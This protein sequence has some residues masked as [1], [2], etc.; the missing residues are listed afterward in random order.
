MRE[1]TTEK[2]ALDYLASHIAAEA[3][4]EGAPLADVE[5]KMLYFSETDW[6][7]PEMA[8]VSAEFDRD[9]LDV[10]FENRIAGLISKLTKGFDG[11]NP[12]EQENWDAAI[13]KLS[14]G[15]RYLMVMVDI[16]KSARHSHASGEFVPTLDVPTVRPPHD[17]LRLVSMAMAIVFGIIGA[18]ALLTWLF[19]DTFWN[20]LGWGL[21][22]KWISSTLVLAIAII[23]VA[24]LRAVRAR[25]LRRDDR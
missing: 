2:A 10:E 18:V 14:E 17:L 4:R 19:G 24:R 1:F 7:L 25:G 12:E 8:E 3:E 6:T 13:K 11:G 22:Q 23:V 9:Y 16:A 5:R 21:N 20:G 15:D